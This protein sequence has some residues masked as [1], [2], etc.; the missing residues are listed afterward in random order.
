VIWTLYALEEGKLVELKSH[1]CDP[2][3]PDAFLSFLDG[4]LALK[5]SLPPDPATIRDELGQQSVAYRAVDQSLRSSWR[6]VGNDPAIAL[7]RQLWAEL[8]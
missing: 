1:R 5:S 3:Q 2:E 4:A 7:K 8:C 6:R